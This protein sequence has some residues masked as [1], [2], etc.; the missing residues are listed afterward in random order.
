MAETKSTKT[1]RKT[2]AKTPAKGGATKRATARKAAPVKKGATAKAA[3]ETTTTASNGGGT[4][5]AK[6]R[7]NAALE[8]AKAGAV[9]LR[10][11]AT[12][13]AGAASDDLMR[14]ARA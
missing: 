10:S 3:E 11:E 7:F 9:A 12:N 4:A 6:S 1:P 2:P 13:R 8:E 5:E 14:E